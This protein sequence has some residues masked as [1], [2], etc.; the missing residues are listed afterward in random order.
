MDT[1]IFRFVSEEPQEFRPALII[2]VF[3]EHPPAQSPHVEILDNDQAE[4]R[5]QPL[6]Q[7]VRVIASKMA[8][9]LVLSRQQE[10]GLLAPDRALAAPR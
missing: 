1:S 7:V 8:N 2:D 9:A 5:D 3:G 4:L 10:A 6:T